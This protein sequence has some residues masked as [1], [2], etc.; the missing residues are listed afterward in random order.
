MTKAAI[1]LDG[2]VVSEHFGKV[3]EFL[4]LTF[5]NGREISR[6]VLPAPTADHAPGVFPNWVKSM[7]ADMVMAGGMG[8]KAKQFFETLGVQ[9][10][11]VP[12]MD[13]EEGVKALLLG[14]VRTV[15]TDCGHGSD[16]DC[17]K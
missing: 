9:V 3:R 12:P 1:A 14:T 4:F 13:V 5:E 6:E 17:G 2:N 7:G 15:E 16:H 8:V 10:L 11:T